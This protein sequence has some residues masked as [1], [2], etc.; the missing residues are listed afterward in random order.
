M[1]ARTNH[2]HTVVTASNHSG[3]IIRDQ[4]KANA[5]RGLRQRWRDFSDRP[6]WSVGG[7]CEWINDLEDLDTVCQYVL[8]GQDR[9]GRD[10][11][12]GLAPRG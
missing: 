2:V 3:K 12:R 10:D 11:N 4:L 6:V 1:N 5:T 7:D 9:K 8:E